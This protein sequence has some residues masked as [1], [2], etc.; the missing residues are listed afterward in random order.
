MVASF[1]EA[2]EPQGQKSHD[3]LR[4]P[5]FSAELLTPSGASLPAFEHPLWMCDHSEKPLPGHQ[6]PSGSGV[7]P[8]LA[9][10]ST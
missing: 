2:Q 5:S 1:L 7:D 6:P 10:E 4:Q 8:H 9:I 3:K